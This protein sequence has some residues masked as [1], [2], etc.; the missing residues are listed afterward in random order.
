[1]W[2]W[3]VCIKLCRKESLISCRAC[4]PSKPVGV[5]I[6]VKLSKKRGNIRP[7][8]LRVVPLDPAQLIRGAVQ[9]HC[10]LHPYLVAMKPS[11]EHLSCELFSPMGGGGVPYIQ[12]WEVVY[13][14]GIVV[15]DGIIQCESND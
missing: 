5:A 1:M 3:L 6:I 12:K 14:E 2:P 8:N 13:K 7:P 9:E 15:A 11:P 10:F 4:D